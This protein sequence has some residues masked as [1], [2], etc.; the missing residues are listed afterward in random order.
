MELNIE[1]DDILMVGTDGMLDNMNDSEIEEIVRRAIN[2]NLKARELAKKIVNVALYN[3]FDRFAD[4]PYAR[5]SKGRHKGGKVDDITVIV[6]YI[7]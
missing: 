5:A 3:S 4:T 2:Q 1:K 7:Q 6:A